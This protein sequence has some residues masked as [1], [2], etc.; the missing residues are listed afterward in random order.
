MSVES[1]SGP[2]LFLHQSPLNTLSELLG[3]PD[4]EVGFQQ[5]LSKRAAELP[6]GSLVYLTL[7][8]KQ[9]DRAHDSTLEPVEC[10]A[11]GS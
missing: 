1:D 2:R 6:H 4:V 8:L 7:A 9:T 5:G 3:L 10:H 11:H